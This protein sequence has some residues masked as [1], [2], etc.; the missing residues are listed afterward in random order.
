MK[1]KFW[2]ENR[3]DK[4]F[5]ISDLELKKR[6][7]VYLENHQK[8]YPDFGREVNLFISTSEGLNSTNDVKDYDKIVEVLYDVYDAFL[9]KVSHG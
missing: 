6:F 5:K 4:E 9:Q 2:K 7:K 8:G 3:L 1:I